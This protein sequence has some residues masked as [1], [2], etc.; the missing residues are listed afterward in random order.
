MKTYRK[1]PIVCLWLLLVLGLL[2]V[3]HATV[4]A[5]QFDE[6]IA[7]YEAG[8]YQKALEKFKSLAEQ[9]DARGQ[10]N[11]G[12]KYDEGEGVPQDYKEAVKWY[13]MAAEQGYAEAQLHLAHLYRVGHRV[14][15]DYA[16][17]A[18]WYR[19]LAEQ[20]HAAAQYFLG[21]IYEYGR[22][23]PENYKE[24]VKWFRMSA[25]QGDAVGQMSLG[26]MYRKGK[27]VP[28]DYVK[29]H[30]WSNLSASLQGKHQELAARSRDIVEEKMTPA[31]V[32]EAQKLAREWKP[33]T[34][35]QLSQQN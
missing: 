6:G 33:K 25:E 8:N 13:R 2:L 34:W 27:G 1:I 12:V 18:K 11:L 14:P 3:T 17:A 15:K 29:A 9:G 26:S 7:A 35:E 20:G 21:D 22:G 32:A 4:K 16:E 23:I 30:K 28:Q 10:Y 31:Q 19:K 24:A 5:D